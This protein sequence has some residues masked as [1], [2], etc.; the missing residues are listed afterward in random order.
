MIDI[1]QKKHP[2]AML[3]F[4]TAP[5]STLCSNLSADPFVVNDLMIED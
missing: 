4:T 2:G 1:Q 5:F 3:L